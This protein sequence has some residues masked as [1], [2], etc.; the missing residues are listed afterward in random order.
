MNPSDYKLAIV[1]D[2][3]SV[4]A[5]KA[6]GLTCVA[7]ESAE[8]AARALRDLSA[9]EK[10]FAIIY[11]TEDLARLIPEETAAYREITVP[12]LILIPSKSGSLGLGLELLTQSA[13]RAAGV[14]LF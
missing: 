11:I 6:L 2:K 7:A 9:P 10:R 4:T 8:E 14:K 3:D 5:F 12:A 13:E 1:G